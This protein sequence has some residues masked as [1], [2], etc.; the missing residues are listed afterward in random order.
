MSAGRICTRVIHTAEPEETIR[1]AADAHG[2]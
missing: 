2:S 1:V